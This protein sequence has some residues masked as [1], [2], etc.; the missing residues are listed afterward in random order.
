MEMKKEKDRE[1]SERERERV[2]D[3]EKE[4]GQKS[5]LRSGHL[6]RIFSSLFGLSLGL[7]RLFIFL[8]RYSFAF[9]VPL[10]PAPTILTHPVIGR[11]RLARG[12]P[13][14]SLPIVALRVPPRQG[15]QCLISVNAAIMA[16]VASA[17]G[18][19]TLGERDK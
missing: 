7:V 15:K 14:R 1:K 16:V 17:R 9:P 4:R 5:I 11:A 10:P 19:S 8:S 18:T 6:A 12:R 3:R 2:P 13:R